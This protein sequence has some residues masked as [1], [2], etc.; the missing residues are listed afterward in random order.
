M[1]EGNI[2]INGEKVPVLIAKK[3]RHRSQGFQSASK[4]TIEST[5]ILFVWSRDVEPVFHMNNVSAPLVIAWIS[6]GEVV[7]TDFMRPGEDGYR[8]PVPVDAALELHPKRANAR[9]VTMG[10]RVDLPVQ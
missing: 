10:A 7:G 3:Q 6:D 8:P 4:E 9:D 2:I 1:P 5:K